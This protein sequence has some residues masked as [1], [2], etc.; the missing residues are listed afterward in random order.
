MDFKLSQRVWQL[1][2]P[3]VVH[4][5]YEVIEVEVHVA[6]RSIVRISLDGPEGITIDKCAE[7]SRIF[8]DV[9]DVENPI[10]NAYVLEVGSPG[11]DR[12][13]RKL[14]HFQKYIGKEVVVKRLNP[15][16]RPKKHRGQLVAADEAGIRLSEMNV[17][18]E[19][20]WNEFH[21][22]RLVH[23]FD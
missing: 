21:S 14:E 23:H 16:G 1:I 22:A 6:R 4:Q 3:V 18:V 10:E 19:V 13:L 9:L 11:F 15:G 5:G 7:F 2:E 8:S 20:P 12:P 17:S